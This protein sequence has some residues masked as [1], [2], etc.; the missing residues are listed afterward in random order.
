MSETENEMTLKDE[1]RLPWLEAVENDDDDDSVSHGKLIGFLLVGLAALGL[2][3]G[4]VWWLRSQSP[5][6]EGDGTL[7]AAQ[8]G[9]YKVKPDAPGGMKV[10]GQG[11]STFAASEGAEANGK[12]DVT[13][14]PEAPVA[15][16]KPPSATPAKAVVDRPA[17]T[18]SGARN[19]GT[20]M[21]CSCRIDSAASLRPIRALRRQPFLIR[22]KP[23]QRVRTRGGPPQPAAF[24][25]GQTGDH[26]LQSLSFQLSQIGDG[27]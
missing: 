8:Q 20:L 17:G 16:Q 23:G 3:V 22:N 13:A 10:E 21:S 2:I 15:K 19:G 9:D 4:G 1:D 25:D 12:V 5:G 24:A 27:T 18:A 14:Q 7:I 11:D 6:A 26:G